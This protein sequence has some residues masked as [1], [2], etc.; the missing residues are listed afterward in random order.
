MVLFSF[1]VRRALAD[2]HLVLALPPDDAQPPQ[3]RRDLALLL[4]RYKKNQ[5]NI[6]NDSDYS[7]I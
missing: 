2:A 4:L 5:I 3:R 1:L 7:D 6:S